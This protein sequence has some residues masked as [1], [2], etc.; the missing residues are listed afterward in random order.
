MATDQ[1]SQQNRTYIASGGIDDDS[2]TIQRFDDGSSIQTFD[3]G[4]TLVIDNEGAVSSTPT[5]PE[6]SNAGTTQSGKSDTPSA[7]NKTPKP[8]KRLQNPLGNFSSYTYQISLYM[9]TPEAYNT[10]VQSGRKNISAFQGVDN[11]NKGAFLVAQSGG[12][13]NSTSKRAPE[14]DVDF[15]ID[16][17]KI[18]SAITGKETL[19]ATHIEE[20]NF[21]IYEPYGFSFL[22]RLRRALEALNQSPPSNANAANGVDAE[23]RNVGIEIRAEDGTLAQSNRNPED[24]SIYNPAVESTSG[25]PNTSSGG[26][27]SPLSAQAQNPTRQFFILGIRFQGYDKNGKLISSQDQSGYN[28]DPTG[29]ANGVYERFFDIKIS[30]LK[31]KIDGRMVVYQCTAVVPKVSEA[32]GTKRGIIDNGVT[33]VGGTVNDAFLGETDGNIG[34]FTKLNND[35]KK[36]KAQGIISIP[37]EFTITYLGNTNITLG[38]ASIVS[39]ADL[40]KLKWKMTNAKTSSEINVKTEEKSTV[41]NTKRQITIRRGVPILQAIQQI[42]S[43]SSFLYAAL[44]KIYTT[45][46]EPTEGEDE[47][48]NSEKNTISWYNVSPELTILGWDDL[49]GDYAYRIN[50]VIQ[51]YST[52]IV[53]SPYVKETPKYYGP[54]KRYDYWFTGKNSEILK[55]EQTFD[56]AYFTVA[57]DPGNSKQASGGAQ[58]V[59]TIANKQQSQPKQGALNLGREAQN[60]YMTSLFDPGAYARAKISI[61]GD[62][63]YLMTTSASSV[64]AVYNRFYGPDGYTINPNGGQVFIEIN[65]KEP[66]DYNNKDGLLSINDSILFYPYPDKVRKDID[67]RGGGIS[68]LV[69]TVYSTFKGGK[70]EQ[71]LELVINTFESLTK[72]PTNPGA[73]P[74]TTATVTDPANQTA[75]VAARTGF[76]PNSTAGAGRG[77]RGG[78]TAAE[79]DAYNVSQGKGFQQSPPITDATGNQTGGGAAF[80]NPNLIRQGNRA[81][82]IQAQQGTK[83]IPTKTGQ[84]QDDDG[85]TGTYFAA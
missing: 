56:Q 20:I 5:P 73:R 16:D 21:N 75:A 39:P 26:K 7:K 74:A 47:E 67:S 34:M 85:G 45:V 77:G 83:T 42:V 22:T 76:V 51:P 18:K 82:N 61:L 27:T 41:D 2:G 52:P 37:N 68:Y 44:N 84:V 17:L 46:E 13:N 14:F 31:F 62:P 60:S 79:L 55:Y 3:D 65:F 38:G 24:G 1:T 69:E 53:N 70:F 66:Q 64:Q 48:V 36:L 40:D 54:S 25:T 63:D 6:F 43:Q 11:T 78:P 32:M 49:T 50:Y 10:F 12:I 29:N 58:Q 71:E 23:G 59:P 35:Q 57:I 15:Y 80:G 81:R 9:I 33:I 4:S 8:G 72:V 19:T 30:E 28:A